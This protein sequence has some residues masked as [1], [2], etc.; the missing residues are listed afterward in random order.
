MSRYTG[1]RIKIVRRLGLLPGLTQKFSNR[2]TTPGQHGVDLSK[3]IKQPLLRNEYSFRL[4]Q[5][6]RLR[7]H[8]GVTE[9]QLMSYYRE[10]KRCQGSTGNLLLE[11]LESRFDSTIFRLGFAPTIPAARQLINHGHFKINGKRVTIPSFLCQPG[12]KISIKENSKVKSQIQNFFNLL[13]ER[14]NGILKRMEEARRTDI[15]IAVLIPN[16]LTVDPVTLE[17]KVIKRVQRNDIPLFV[18]ELK[19]VEHYSR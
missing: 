1:P 16:H 9:R 6:Q 11:L 15:K 2:T 7:F 10:A 19:V 14:R 4:F 8:Y 17:A 3:T 12:D 13:Q 18:N 5:R